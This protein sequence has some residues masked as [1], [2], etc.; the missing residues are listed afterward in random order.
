MRFS[1]NLLRELGTRLPIILGDS[2]I[3]RENIYT[4]SSV[5][6]RTTNQKSTKIGEP[7]TKSLRKLENCRLSCQS[8]SEILRILENVWPETRQ[9]LK[10]LFKIKGA[11]IKFKNH[12]RLTFGPRYIHTAQKTGP[13]ISCD[14]P[15]RQGSDRKRCELGKELTVAHIK[16]RKY[17]IHFCCYDELL[18]V[19]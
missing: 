1:S 3:L 4:L 14:S 18:Y 17:E 15:F 12:K 9:N 13:K 11:S 2:M 6:R 10:E 5:S 8:F 7:L 19:T 16:K